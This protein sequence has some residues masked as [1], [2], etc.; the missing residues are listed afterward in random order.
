MRKKLLLGMLLLLCMSSTM[1]QIQDPWVGT[2]TSESYKAVDN[3]SEDLRYTDYRY[4]IKIT[5]NG[6]NYLVRAKTVKV[7]DPKHAIYH[8]AYGFTQIVKQLEDNSMMIESHRDEIP[9][10]VNG[11]IDSYSNTVSYFKLTLNNGVIH[12]S[13]YK[14]VVE[15]YNKDMR[16][17]YKTIY[18]LYDNHPGPCVERDMYNDEW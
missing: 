14:Y 1:A 11:Q 16:F 7:S 12:Y 15:S 4:I 6:D 3:D 9:F 18:G 13:F 8:D 2:W 10:Y 5:K 17:E